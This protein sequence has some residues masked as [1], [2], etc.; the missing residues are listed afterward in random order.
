M[1]GRARIALCLAA[2]AL[3]ALG[4]SPAPATKKKAPKPG[5]L[6]TTTAT[7]STTTDDQV[8]TATATCPAK[9]TAVGGGFVAGSL[10]A[11]GSL[12]DA[13]GLL[14]SRRASS[15][16]WRVTAIRVD[17]G[18]AGPALPLTAEVY[19][20]SAAGKISEAAGTTS[21]P[22]SAP[23][24]YSASVGCPL[25]RPA[26]A[27]GFLLV[28]PDAGNFSA[29]LLAEVPVGAVGRTS[30]G[31]AIFAGSLSVGSYAY[32]RK[33]GKAPTSLT[34]SASLPA[35]LDAVASATTPACPAKLLA[36]GG[37]F[38]GPPFQPGTPLPLLLESRRAGNAWRASAARLGSGTPG[39]FSAFA[40]C[41]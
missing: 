29:L 21:I 10:S 7:V 4:S 24:P 33:G 34:A 36:F 31:L 17:T 11:G 5:K 41:S 27:G 39:Q 19:C 38:A 40:V 22:N 23:I 37:G 2:V 16:S 15:R 6:K 1:N 12:T 28:P 13:N 30:R 35:T 8:A 32:C 3:L 18:G 25:A 14:E 20:R 9:T 26:V